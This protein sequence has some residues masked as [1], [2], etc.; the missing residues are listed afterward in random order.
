M[1]EHRSLILLRSLAFFF[2]YSN[3][4][5]MQRKRLVIRLL[6]YQAF[7]TQQLIR[8]YKF[9]HIGSSPFDGEHKIR[10]RVSEKTST[11]IE[12]SKSFKGNDVVS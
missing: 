1:K 8:K 2:F 4:Q 3:M 12:S 9:M 6:L 7:V 11:S 5:K 10:L